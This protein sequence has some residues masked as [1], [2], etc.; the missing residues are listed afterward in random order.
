MFH[1]LRTRVL[2]LLLR[3]P[4]SPPP[5]SH[6][7]PLHRLL[8]TTASISP[9]PFSAK[10]FLV[11]DCGLT[12]AQALKASRRLS[13]LTSLSKPQATVAFLLGRGVPRSDIAVAVVAD[14]S[15]L[16]AS[17]GMVLAP[18]F[19]ELSELGFSPSQ[20]VAILSIRRTGALRGNLLFWFGIFDSYPKLLFLAKSNRELLSASIEKVIKPNLATLQECGI[21]APDI[22]VLSLYSCRLFTVKPKF[23]VDAVARIE[24]LGVQRSSWMFR[25]ALAALAFK[26][27]DVLARKIQFLHTL[28]FSQDDLVNIAK[29]AALVLAL[30][31]KKIQRSV[32]FLMKD[33]GLQA[34]YIARRP[35]LIMYSVE[36]WLLPRY[37]L[38]KLLRQKGL[39]DVELDYYTMASLAEKKFVQNFV[40]PYKDSVPGLVDEYASA[41]RGKA[42]KG[43]ARL[44]R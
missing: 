14:P 26:S 5:P 33:V 25:R 15:L 20:I 39:L 17:V 42:P 6:L 9:K 23:L 3:Y 8:S 44:Q 30:S 36:R 1:H 21:S 19:A 11:T 7:V 27:K 28:G 29:K 16:Y 22:A 4:P 10:D 24:E 2:P 12:R 37:S 13:N 38:L 43:S 41:C 40:D 18:R 34:S 32:G 35:A 31:D